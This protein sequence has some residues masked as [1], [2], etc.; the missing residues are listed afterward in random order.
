MQHSWLALTK[1]Y[2]LQKQVVLW[3]TSLLLF[4]ATITGFV[5]YWQTFYSTNN[6]EDE[7][8]KTIAHLV[9]QQQANVPSNHLNYSHYTT[10]DG[11]SVVSVDIYNKN[12]TAQNA[13]WATIAHIPQ[14]F[15]LENAANKTWQIYRLDNAHQ[16]IIT[17]QD[18]TFQNTLA[19]TNAIQSI[20]PILIAIVLLMILLPVLFSLL[21]KGVTAVSAEISQRHQYDLQPLSIA[22]IPQDILPMLV[23]I[24]RLF[25][26]LKDAFAQQQH[27]IADVSH[28]L[29]SPLTAM[30]LQVQRIQRLNVAD[31]L[32]PELN[33]LAMGV[34]RN[35]DLVEQLLALARIEATSYLQQAISLEQVIEDV[36]S[37]LLPLAD[38]KSIQFDVLLKED[39]AVISDETALLIL[40]KNLIQNAILYSP[41][42]SHISL[43]TMPFEQWL[44]NPQPKPTRIVFPN[45]LNDD[46]VVLQIINQG[47]G[48]NPCD[49]ERVFEPFI[50]LNNNAVNGS[51]LGL[52]VVKSI[53]EKANI[54]LFFSPSATSDLKFQTTD[55]GLC[56]SLVFT[57]HK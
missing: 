37:L 39:Y 30:S 57:A 23:A 31:H 52:V 32:K 55:Y 15:S 36:L 11:D 48:I 20:V 21:L 9:A 45:N 13:D 47:A 28:E 2:S 54:G 24:N 6:I 27:F 43:V 53:C 16:V 41:N 8:L 3:S 18:N 29:R 35:Q 46:A 7:N 22:H 4:L 51:G 10:N 49:Y 38:E 40:I 12:A 17:R 25:E 56:V 42:D 33:K 50:R 5:T 1:S 44:T 34:K 19:K 26:Q 14:G